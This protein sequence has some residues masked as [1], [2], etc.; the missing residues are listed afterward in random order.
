M[1]DPTAQPPG[2][3]RS[4]ASRARRG[5]D[6][7][8]SPAEP[9]A[10]ALAALE[11]AI[12]HRFSDRSQLLAALTH[13][14]FANDHHGRGVT[15][16][17]RLE[18]LGDAVVGCVMADLLFRRDPKAREGTLTLRRAALV[19][20][21]RLA[22][23]ARDLS[24]PALIRVGQGDEASA[25]PERDSVLADVFEA[26]I[27]AIWVDAGHD[28]L[29]CID[30]LIARLFE[31]DLADRTPSRALKPPKSRLQELSQERWKI[32]PRYRLTGDGEPVEVT[33]VIGDI[34]TLTATG[35]NRRDA[36]NRAALTA[37]AHL[38]GETI[39]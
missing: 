39:P 22:E 16:Y 19:K 30:A 35:A 7:V 31:R 9:P 20:E 23:A 18:F 33:V 37:I 1:S 4:R 2:P 3:S 34:L 29:P 27:A 36:E 6:D 14:S 25:F 12:G 21:A 15:D 11:R 10:E 8:P 17:Q 24:L 13:R 32:T 38:E 5:R 26:L 28:A